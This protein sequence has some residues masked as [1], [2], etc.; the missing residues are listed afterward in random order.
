MVTE[1]TAD[2]GPDGQSVPAA[3]CML[4]SAT[5]SSSQ[6]AQPLDQVAGPQ[7]ERHDALVS[8]LW[9]SP[10]PQTSFRVSQSA[11]HEVQSSPAETVHRPSPHRQA[12]Q[13]VEQEAQVSPD[14]QTPSP[15]AAVQSASV[16]TLHAL[17]QQPSPPVHAVIASW[18]QA[19]LQVDALPV[20]PSVV[21]A[22]PSLQV[23]GQDEGGSQVS[24][25]ST[26]PLPQVGEQSPSVVASQP[27][28]QHP[29]PPVQ[30]VT[31]LC[32]QARLH[33]AA[34]PEVTSVVQAIPSSQVDGQDE[35]GSQVSPASTTPFPQ[36]S[37]Q[38]P[39][40]VLSHPSGQ[41]PSP[42]AQA[43]MAVTSHETSQV[44]GSPVRTSVVHATPSSQVAGQE[45]GGSQV[46]PAPTTPS[47]QME[48][49]SGRGPESRG[50]PPSPPVPPSR[51]GITSPSRPPPSIPAAAPSGSSENSRPPKELPSQAAARASTERRASR[52]PARMR[53]E[54]SRMWPPYH[55]AFAI[56]RRPLR[57]PP[58]GTDVPRPRD[59]I[60]CGP[61][62]W[63]HPKRLDSAGPRRHDGG[64]A[65]RAA[66]GHMNRA[67]LWTLPALAGAL[68]LTSPTTARAGIPE[69]GGIRLEDAT[70]CELRAEVDCEAGCAE[71][72]IYETACATRLHTVCRSEC[73]LS[74]EPTCTDS[75]TTMCQTECDRGVPITCI[76]NC[77]A[78][79]V[80]SCDATCAGAADQGRCMASCEATCDGECDVQ[81]APVV[82]AS[83]YQHC[84]ECCGGS[85]GAQAN[86][87]CQTVCQDMQF[88]DC[89]HEFR[90]DCMASCSADGA[91]F[92]DGEYVLS[93]SQLQT[94]IDAL[95]ER[96]IG[97]EIRAEGSVT[98][99]GEGASTSCSA[100]HADDGAGAGLSGGAALV[101]LL[102]L[103]RTRRRRRTR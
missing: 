39:S 75:C 46:S 102:A 93:G 14:V 29:S 73:T 98:I 44:L 61:G 42:S 11:P 34:L 65:R 86:M 83:C 38:S 85:C 62:S 27:P 69:C 45:P 48:P 53:T 28:G 71:L 97:G 90:A 94:C 23:D 7:S 76:H 51:P 37:E 17:G 91:L 15:Q 18:E 95:L 88:E 89:E 32:E 33:V 43:S 20:V 24:P 40:V 103:R 63:R 3:R 66:R 78:E 59:A 36:L 58:L 22:I 100:T 8:P 80:G 64:G 4:K 2:F 19:R 99:G 6:V 96:G 1:P 72:G 84:V 79:C 54:Y 9:H 30:A 35:G 12:P 81:C 82:D 56:L 70:N 92:C 101:A 67:C 57:P 52:F 10:F 49:E 47:P 13:S 31:A 74:A 5:T 87:D 21:Q 50:A 41:H 55:P 25:D 16:E 68:L 60:E 77:F 26:T